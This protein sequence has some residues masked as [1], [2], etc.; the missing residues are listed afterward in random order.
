MAYARV[1]YLQTNVCHFFNV[2]YSLIIIDCVKKKMC[3]VGLFLLAAM[4]HIG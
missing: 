4:A 3:L 2:I 1:S